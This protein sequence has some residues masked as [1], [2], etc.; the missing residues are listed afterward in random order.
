MMKEKIA[1]DIRIYKSEIPNIVGNVLPSSINN[2]TLN[3]VLHRI[4]MKLRENEFSLGEFDHLYIN[5]TTCLDKGFMMPAKRGRDPHHP[6]YR[7]YD[8]GVDE[9]FYNELDF[10]KSIESI[11]LL[12]EKL[13]LQYF[14]TDEATQEIV[15]SS[16]KDAVSQKE[17]MLMR[18]KVKET[19]NRKAV[20]YLRYL[21]SGNYY[22]LLC[23]YD[24]EGNELLK[25][26]LSVSS[27]LNPYGIICLSS[28]KVIIKQKSNAFT[29]ELKPI[30][31]D[32]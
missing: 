6:W 9:A 30:S 15:E 26:D 20:L 10:E 21:D 7:Y 16:I 4:M 8:I 32:F 5:F 1:S 13:L 17:D 14:A 19:V 31:F 12:V 18:Y 23:V 3:V 27:D 24:V 28:K 2:K 25:K 11:I 29:V 22:P